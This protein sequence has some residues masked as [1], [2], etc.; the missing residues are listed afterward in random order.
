MCVEMQR[1]KRIEQ[2]I[3][4]VLK[5]ETRDEAQLGLLQLL[6]KTRRRMAALGYS[7]E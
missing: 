5:R 6:L 7:G 4:W 2:A 3:K 1:L